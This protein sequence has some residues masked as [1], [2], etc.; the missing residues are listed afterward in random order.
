MVASTP[1]PGI[2]EI[3]VL[4]EPE[5][6]ILTGTEVEQEYLF[7]KR[8]GVTHIGEMASTV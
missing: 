8:L 4:E 1:V 7:D 3:Q 2:S 6:Q 5:L